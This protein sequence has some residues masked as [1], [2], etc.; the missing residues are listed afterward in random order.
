M[1]TWK[2]L[3]LRFLR[4]GLA[5]A[6]ALMLTVAI[7]NAV[8]GDWGDI[9]YWLGKLAIAGTIGFVSGLIFAIDKAFRLE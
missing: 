6:I 1:E 8:E 9:N 4:G 7:P 2:I 5:T 3:G